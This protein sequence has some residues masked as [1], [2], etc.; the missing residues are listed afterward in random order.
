MEQTRPTSVALYCRCVIWMTAVSLP[1]KRLPWIF[2]I[3]FSY[4]RLHSICHWKCII[5]FYRYF[6][7][8]FSQDEED[9]TPVVHALPLLS[10]ANSSDVLDMPVDPNEPTYCLCHQ[11]SYGE[12]I[13]CDNPD[14]CS[15]NIIILHTL[16]HMIVFLLVCM[17]VWERE[18]DWNVSYFILLSLF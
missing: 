17:C 2:K 3:V 10:I 5:W 1:D 12:M 7:V 13:G 6:I 18:R 11:V 8:H 16:C 14:V 15:I 4:Y 9:Q